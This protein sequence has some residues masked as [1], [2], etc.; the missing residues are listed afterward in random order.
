MSELYTGGLDNPIFNGAETMVLDPETHAVAQ[1]AL[2]PPEYI[3][4][5]FEY[6]ESTARGIE[7][8]TDP[9]TG[10]VHDRG[11]ITDYGFELSNKTSPTNVGLQLA[12]HVVL[13]K[14][15]IMA[16]DVAEAKTSRIL[17]SVEKMPNYKGLLYG[18][19]DPRDLSVVVD[20]NDTNDRRKNGLWI[21]SVDN[22]WMAEGLAIV[23]RTSTNPDIVEKAKYLLHRMSFAEMYDPSTKMYHGE[24]DANTGIKSEFHYP[25]LFSETRSIVYAG[26]RYFDMPTESLFSLCKYAPPGEVAPSGMRP[27][28]LRTFG[29]AMFEAMLPKQLFPEDLWSPHMQ[30]AGLNVVE[31]QIRHGEEYNHGYWGF[32]PCEHADPKVG[33][34]TYGTPEYSISPYGVEGTIT[35]HAVALAVIM[36]GKR[37]IRQ[38]IRQEEDFPGLYDS[39]YGFTDSANIRVSDD[40]KQERLVAGHILALD[41]MMTTI[42]L[43]SGLTQGGLANYDDEGEGAARLRNAVREC[44]SDPSTEEGEIIHAA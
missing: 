40:G 37:A 13:E 10:L 24:I 23:A 38:L 33:Y 14:L 43:F 35:P 19:Y 16:G 20:P 25:L 26:I 8:M 5:V 7:A 3:P 36:V 42:G 9:A 15:G 32:S 39:R 4:K 28:D 31:S 1:E 18:W 41:A 22:A 27:S 30:Q 11:K 21:S 34:R 12:H 44:M 2:I 29:G 6:V 17:D